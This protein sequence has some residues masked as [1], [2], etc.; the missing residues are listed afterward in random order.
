MRVDDSKSVQTLMQI[1]DD[2]ARLPASPAW[3]VTAKQPSDGRRGGPWQH[4]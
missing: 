1:H 3:Q 2:S 4:R